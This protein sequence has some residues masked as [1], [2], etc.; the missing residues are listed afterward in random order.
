MNTNSV[1]AKTAYEPPALVKLGSLED[2][3]RQSYEG[4]FW[5][6]HKPWHPKPPNCPPPV[7]S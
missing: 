4:S 1:P 7:F 5:H 2:L 6:W 3:T